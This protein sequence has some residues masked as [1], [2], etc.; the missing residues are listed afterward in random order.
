MQ[1]SKSFADL[2]DPGVSAD[3]RDGCTL[4]GANS[5]HSPD[6]RRG[7]CNYVGYKNMFKD[8]AG[9]VYYLT[10]RVLGFVVVSGGDLLH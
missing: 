2:V 7:G 5:Q 6:E 10:G 4:F 1:M 9:F 3:L 8:F